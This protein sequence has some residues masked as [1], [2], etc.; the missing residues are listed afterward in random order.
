MKSPTTHPRKIVGA[1]LERGR[2]IPAIP[3]SVRAR[4][5][6]RARLSM[7]SISREQDAGAAVVRSRGLAMALGAV[8]AFVVGAAVAAVALRNGEPERPAAVPPPPQQVEQVAC[9]T[10]VPSPPTSSIVAPEPS[11]APKRQPAER[12]ISPRESYAAELRV[13]QR[14]QAAYRTQDFAT[15][16]RLVAEHQRRFPNGRLAQEREALRVKALKG[17]GR[18]KEASQAASSF[19]AEYPRSP[20]LR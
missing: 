15:T 13:L 11:A 2:K 12:P 7:G 10:P 1:L 5:L 20:L 18:E 16:L 3:D 8:V 9:A 14:A 6:D 19:E 17:A 4:T